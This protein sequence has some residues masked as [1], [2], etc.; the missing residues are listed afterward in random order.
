MVVVMV[1]LGF[2]QLRRL[3]EKRDL[4]A[5]VDARQ[6]QPV[7]PV[8]EIVDPGAAV[9]DPEVV[10]AE[11][12]T[13][14]A[15]GTYLP[16]SVV[17]VNRS[18]NGAAGGWVL[19]P[20]DLGDGTAVVVNRGFIGFDRSGDLVAPDPP[21]GTVEVTGLVR[22][23][24]RRGSIGPTD[25]AEGV[26]SQLARADLE[27]YQ[28]QVEVDLLPVYLQLVTSDPAEVTAGDGP[29]LVPLDP[30]EPGEGPH[31]GYALQWFTFSTI[32]VVGYPLIL[33]RV[34]QQEARERRRAEAAGG[35]GDADRTPD[36]LARSGS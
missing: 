34:A 20:L 36:E 28:R 12:R 17:V 9:D 35:P 24:Q 29:V 5:R 27:R 11:H 32:A 3:D 15:R 6:A 8:A 23:T 1:N 33:R 19:T 18:Y 21:R 26:L 2:W 13:A 16:D 31:L 25:P 30:P 14:S 7:E 22:L 4:N 10:R